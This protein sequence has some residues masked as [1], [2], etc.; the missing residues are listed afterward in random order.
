M[1][2]ASLNDI[3]KELRTLG[4]D[5]LQK[6][7]IRLARYKKENTELLTYLLYEAS[8]EAAYVRSVN[9]E[10]DE[11]FLTLPTGNLYYV[12]KSLRKI[13]RIAN[14]QIKYSGIRETE[15]GIRIHFCAKVK[16]AKIPVTAGTVL[17]NLY[18]QQVKK[19][20]DVWSKLPEDLQADYERELKKL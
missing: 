20:N 2:P 12:K 14:R 9:E 6:L 19:I 17:G 15:L 11:L 16:E 18:H 8:D 13:L 5:E 4:S 3:R 10:L 1:K 7:C